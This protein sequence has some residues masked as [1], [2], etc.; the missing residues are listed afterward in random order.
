MSSLRRHTP[1]LLGVQIP[2]GVPGMRVVAAITSVRG[3]GSW[4]LLADYLPVATRVALSQQLRL[5]APAWLPAGAIAIPTSGS[6]A[7]PKLVIHTRATLAASA[8]ATAVFLGE[9]LRWFS[10]L[11]PASIASV[12]CH[13]RSERTGDRAGIWRGAGGGVPFQPAEFAAQLRRFRSRPGAPVGISVVST[14]LHHILADRAATEVSRCCAVVLVGG[15]P[16]DPQLRQQA[17]AAGIRVVASYG[18]TETAGGCVYDGHPLPGVRVDVREG[19]V[20]VAGPM[21]AAGYLP[22]KA[23]SKAG[24]A[25]GDLGKLHQASACGPDT[26]AAAPPA[27]STVLEI[28]GRADDQVTVKGTNVNIGQVTAVIT[29]MAEVAVAATVAVPDPVHGH[30]LIAVVV[31]GAASGPWQESTTAALALQRT[32]RQEVRRVCGSAAVPRVVLRTSLPYLATGK[33]DRQ[34]LRKE[35]QLWQ[36]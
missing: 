1:G 17:E 31:P 33:I 2:A 32:I 16:L 15:G 7:S 20:V 34:R 18:M 8:E 13:L 36:A 23:F 25:T 28:T 4:A 30:A 3:Y 21:L 6:A 10:G 26:A 19:E 9:E 24:F 14:Q 35:V 22:A 27:S 12:M 11:P 29:A 5:P